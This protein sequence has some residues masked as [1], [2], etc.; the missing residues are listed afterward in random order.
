[1]ADQELGRIRSV[2]ARPAAPPIRPHGST[3]RGLGYVPR[4]VSYDGR[5]GRIFRSLPPLQADGKDLAKLA[6]TMIEGEEKPGVPIDEEDRNAPSNNLGVPAGFTYLGQFLDHDMTFDPTSKL[7]RDNDPDGLRNFRTPRFDLD[8]LYGSG[9]D[10][11]P[12]LYSDGVHFLIGENQPTPGEDDLPRTVRT[13]HGGGRAL[14][15]DPRNDENQ[16][17]SQIHL[18][19]LKFHNRVVDDIAA[20]AGAPTDP[21]TLFEMARQQVRWHYQF[22]ILTDFLPRIIGQGVVDD[23]IKK[24]EFV[25]ADGSGFKKASI[26]KPNLKF[27][28]WHVQPFMPVEFSVAAYRFGHSMVRANYALNNA[29]SGDDASGNSKE[30]PIFDPGAP[31]PTDTPKDLRGFQPRPFGRRIFWSRF[32]H[33]PEA[34][35]KVELQPARAFDTLLAHGLGGLPLAVAAQG[36]H[37]LAE[38]NLKRG[39]ALELPAG[40]VVARA[41][42]LSETLV[43]GGAGGPKFEVGATYPKFKDEEGNLRDDKSVVKIDPGLKS[44]LEGKFGSETPLWY[45]ILKEAEVLTKGRT[46]G[47]VGGRIVGEVFVGLL[48]ADQLSYLNIQPHWRPTAGQF[49]CMDNGRFHMTDLLRYAVSG[50]IIEAGP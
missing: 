10:D 42:G 24:E 31:G 8:S 47:P 1:M 6:A 25:V 22:M 4:S 23:L 38:R 34:D 14:I 40:Q 26:F 50:Q 15:G 28:Q 46:L 12:Y 3:P 45:Y 30:L 5:F 11:S 48:F 41:M 13:T 18:A 9:P 19:F 16:I 7:G 17:V 49:G 35:G 44:E 32:F 27:F 43:L 29:T 2:A 36:P 37:S 39:L 20:R 21:G 33:F